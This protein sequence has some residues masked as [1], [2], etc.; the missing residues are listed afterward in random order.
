M[1]HSILVS[2]EKAHGVN[3]GL[4]ILSEMAFGEG[5]NA[6]KISDQAD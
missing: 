4:Y 2:E 1:C 3:R 5:T 6:L